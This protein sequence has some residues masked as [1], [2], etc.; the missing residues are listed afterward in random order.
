MRRA[1][2]SPRLPAPMGPYSPALV[3]GEW[4]HL[5]GRGAPAPDGAAD[6][7]TIERQTR[8]TLEDISLLLQEAG[9]TLDDVVSCVVYLSDLSL[10]ARFN[11]VYADYFAEPRPARTTLGAMLLPGMLVEIT[12]VAYRPGA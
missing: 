3:V 4:I 6:T 7:D 12:A 2:A 1:I 5:A 9:A 8:R 11:T 10:F